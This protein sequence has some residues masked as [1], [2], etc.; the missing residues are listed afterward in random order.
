[1]MSVFFSPACLFFLIV[2]VG[3]PLGKIKIGGISL[4]LAAVLLTAI[5]GGVLLTRLSPDTISSAFTQALSELS[6]L[7]TALFVSAVGLQAGLGIQKASKKEAVL[8][9]LLGVSMVAMGFLASRLLQYCDTTLSLSLS[10]GIFCGAMTSSP[11]L[12]SVCESGEDAMAA[13]LGYGMAYPLGVIVT[14]LWVQIIARNAIPNEERTEP[15]HKKTEGSASLLPIISGIC[16]LGFGLGKCPLIGELIGR[17]GSILLLSMI[18]GACLAKRC[19]TE[20]GASLSVYRTLGLLLFFVGNGI[21]AGARLGGGISLR[22][23]LYA[24]IIALV[25]LVV[26]TLVC[27]FA[28]HRSFADTACLLAGGM[29]STPALGTILEKKDVSPDLSL[30]S[31]S[32][33]GALL[34]ATLL[35]KIF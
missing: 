30:Y 12:A 15:F 22:P 17:T 26:G 18:V 25:P 21:S 10:D 13:T 4:G 28:W 35:P 11:A 16:V 7:G 19:K 23:F 8:A 33:I 2:A 27:R 1:M 29:T 3:W 9:A 5:G 24:L 32:Y 14:V 20:Q 31:F 6:V 34:A